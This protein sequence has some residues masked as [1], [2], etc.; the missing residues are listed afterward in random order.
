METHFISYEMRGGLRGS[1]QGGTGGAP[2]LKKRMT[3]P[4]MRDAALRGMRKKKI[5]NR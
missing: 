2:Y 4:A 5:E 3:R 1:P